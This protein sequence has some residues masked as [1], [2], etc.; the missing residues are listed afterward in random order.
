M[1]SENSSS[2]RNILI[3]DPETIEKWVKEDFHFLVEEYGLTYLREGE[4]K[5]AFLSPKVHIKVQ[6]GRA[7][8]YILIHRPGERIYRPG[9]P[10]FSDLAF[11][12]IVQYFEGRL[13]I[14][15]IY[16][17]YNPNNP[18]GENIRFM[19]G[20]FKRYASRII[21]QIDEWWLP[22]HVFQY[23][24]LE[25]DYKEAGQLDDFLTSYKVYYDY[26]KSKGAIE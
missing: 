19:A 26:L 3:P 23:R 17:G 1:T 12:R 24:L 20:I 2:D 9:E 5:F 21:N 7:T 14:S 22:V 11:G 15:D 10:D 18:L 8:P 25:Q 16:H 6:P 13:D 4:R